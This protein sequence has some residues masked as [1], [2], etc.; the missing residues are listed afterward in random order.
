MPSLR[1]R[2]LY[3]SI[4][5]ESTWAGW[6]CGFIRLAGCDLRCGYC[7]EV[8]AFQGGESLSLEQVM[9]RVERLGVHLVEI[10][11]GEP[12]LQP[13]TRELAR[14]LLEA[15]HEVLVETAGH[16]DISQLDPR[17]HVILDVKTPGS[18]M[19]EHFDPGNLGRLGAGDEVKF[20]LVDRADYE[21]ARDFTRKHR[22]ETRTSVHFSPVHPGLDPAAL[23]EWILEDR[24]RV[25]L[26][27]QLHKFVWGSQ[28]RGV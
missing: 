26:N 15:G 23:V 7:D 5:G 10:T 14:R 12:L 1:V 20:V 17:C 28:A 16:R 22:L 27:L 8:H 6:P 3:A 11:G 19:A 9:D 18:G 13:A 2:E 4:Q 21:W 24:L 25:R